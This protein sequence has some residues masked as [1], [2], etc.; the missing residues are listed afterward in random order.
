MGISAEGYPF[1]AQTGI[2]DYKLRLPS[3]NSSDSHSNGRVVS[4]VTNADSFGGL[5]TETDA[6]FQLANGPIMH[7]D[8]G[9]A[10][11]AY[12]FFLKICAASTVFREESIFFVPSLSASC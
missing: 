7:G 4:V 5:L 2:A 3:D 9:L 10:V 6:Q 8:V 1:P 12:F 11:G